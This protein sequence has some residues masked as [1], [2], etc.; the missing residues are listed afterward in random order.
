MMPRIAIAKPTLAGGMPRLPVNK[1]G[2]RCVVWDAGDGCSGSKRLA[3]RKMNQRLLK[4]P[5]W[6]ATR[7]W[8]SKVRQTLRVQSLRNGSFRLG[9][10]VVGFLGED[11]GGDSSS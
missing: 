8:V 3:E 4:V 11:C 2:R 7:Q 5:R 6:K 9:V 10:G 1:N